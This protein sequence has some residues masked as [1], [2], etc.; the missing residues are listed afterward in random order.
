MHEK[1]TNNIIYEMYFPEIVEQDAIIFL[2]QSR[3][4]LVCD[5]RAITSSLNSSDGQMVMWEVF[6]CKLHVK[7]TVDFTWNWQEN[8]HLNFIFSARFM[9]KLHT[10]ILPRMIKF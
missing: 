10:V 1:L 9:S 8:F 6:S 3:P 7:Y 2:H 5:I 4:S